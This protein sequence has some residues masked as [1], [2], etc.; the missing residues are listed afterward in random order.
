MTNNTRTPEQATLPKREPVRLHYRD[1]NALI[2]LLEQDYNLADLSSEEKHAYYR[3][4]EIKAAQEAFTA[5][6]ERMALKNES[7]NKV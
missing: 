2:N 7:S 3:L 5:H 6:R 1:V 4:K